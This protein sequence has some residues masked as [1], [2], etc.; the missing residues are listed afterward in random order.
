L[1]NLKKVNLAKKI[2]SFT[3]EVSSIGNGKTMDIGSM[4][5]IA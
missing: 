1:N 2:A 5:K 3:N 4:E